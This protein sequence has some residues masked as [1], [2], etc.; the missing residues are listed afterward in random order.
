MPTIISTATTTLVLP[1]A[2]LR[3]SPGETRQ[4]E[5][6]TPNM[7]NAIKHQRLKVGRERR[8]RKRTPKP[9]PSPK[10]EKDENKDP[11]PNLDEPLALE[12]IEVEDDPARLIA[13]LDQETRVEVLDAIRERLDD[14]KDDESES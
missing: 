14:L 8:T 11:I 3:L 5:E 7:K 13:L 6:I 1:D 4:V 9:K 2:N 10:A 12:A